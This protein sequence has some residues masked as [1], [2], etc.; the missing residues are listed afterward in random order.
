LIKSKQYISKDVML[1]NTNP[2]KDVIHVVMPKNKV[3]QLADK[4]NKNGQASTGLM[5]FTLQPGMR[6]V[7]SNSNS[8]G[9]M[10]MPSMGSMTSGR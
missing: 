2:N 3:I 10:S 6:L 5:K 1:D 8:M 9:S 7:A 4:V